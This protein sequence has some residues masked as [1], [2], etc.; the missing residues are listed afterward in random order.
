MCLYPKLIRNPKY[1][2]NKKNR[3]CV[4]S[5]ADSRTLFV[6]I[7]CGVCI[8]CCKKKAREWQVRLNEELKVNKNSY[9]VTLTFDEK[10][11]EK[12]CT[13]KKQYESNYIASV[14][15]RRFLERYRKKNKKSIKH[16]LVTELGQDKTERIHL[17]GII[18]G[19][20]IEEIK[21]HWKYGIFD[22][23]KY[24]NSQ[25]ISYIV[26]YI[27]KIDKKHKNFKP[28]I[29]CS[30]GIGRNYIENPFS[31]KN[32][33]NE[34][35]TNENYRLSNGQKIALPIYYRNYIYTEEEREK[36]WLEKLDKQER[37]VMGQKI[38]IN[39]ENGIK[40]YN[41]I[42]KN[43]QEKNKKLGY[44]DDSQ[45]WKKEKYNVTNHHINKL[46]K[47]KKYQEEKN[48]LFNKL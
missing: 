30:K 10:E 20:D 6:P 36:L 2:P 35:G 34:N 7:G 15:I 47:E 3:Y 23:G 38:K 26:K 19:N 41:E 40:S 28:Q 17:H 44:G 48:K 1:L 39:D 13:E 14:A 22:I 24:C 11:L 33:Y 8:E 27:T 31:T 25:T 32:K 45:K 16:W 37:W 12:L 9:F 18:W 4:P 21:S 42:L 5:V 43:A 29:F 46:T